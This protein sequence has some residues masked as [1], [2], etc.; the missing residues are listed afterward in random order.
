[1][2]F[3]LAS[4]YLP[5]T[6]APITRNPLK[7]KPIC[8]E[9]LA[10]INR[11]PMPSFAAV[12]SLAVVPTYASV[13][14]TYASV[15]ATLRDAKKSGVQRGRPTV[16]NTSQRLVPSTRST[17]SSSG[18]SV[19]RPVAMLTLMGKKEIKNAVTRVGPAS[20]PNHTTKMGTKAASAGRWKP[21]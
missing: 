21:S 13:V 1:M 9:L 6:I 8:I 10:C 18:S 14:P 3:F 20:M 12:I 16:L 17:C 19:A 5:L 2:R 4:S 7:A 15:M 11:Q